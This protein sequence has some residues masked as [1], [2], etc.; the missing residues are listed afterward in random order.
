MWTEVI[1]E[2]MAQ[3]GDFVSAVIKDGR[4]LKPVYHVQLLIFPCFS[5]T[6][7]NCVSC[8]LGPPLYTCHKFT[9]SRYKS[10]SDREGARNNFVAVWSVGSGIQFQL[11]LSKWKCSIMRL[12][13][14]LR[15]RDRQECLK[16]VL[17][18]NL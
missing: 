13:S 5:S 11:D 1:S 15:F 4:Y 10:P 8:T 14:R 3:R 6:F 7:R 12:S 17:A 16:R 18:G 2:D 9:T